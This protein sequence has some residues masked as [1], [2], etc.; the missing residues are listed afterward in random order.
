MPGNIRTLC[1]VLV[2]TVLAALH[3]VAADASQGSK[4]VPPWFALALAG[5]FISCRNRDK[6]SA[7]DAVTLESASLNSVRQ[8]TENLKQFTST[9]KTRPSSLIW[10][11]NPREHFTAEKPGKPELSF[12]CSPCVSE[13]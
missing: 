6:W 9:I 7:P 2:F 5:G 10:V 4:R 13:C 12:P 3:A 11:T 1:L 8:V